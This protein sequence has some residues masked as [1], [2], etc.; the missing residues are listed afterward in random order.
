MVNRLQDLV[1][2][3][4]AA[5]V[6]DFRPRQPIALRDADTHVFFT[7]LHY[8]PNYAYPL[9]VWLH[10]P[11]DNETQL[12]QVLPLVSVRNYVA[13][14][15]RGTLASVQSGEQTGYRWQQSADLILLAE[16][17]VLR[18]I[19]AA[20]RRFNVHDERIVLAGLGCGGTMAVRLALQHPHLVSGAVSL[21]GPF[22]QDHSPLRRWHERRR[23]RLL[24]ASGQTSSEYPPEHVCRDLA[25]FHAANMIVHLR[26]YPCGD[27]LTTEMLADVDR[28][29]MHE[30]IASQASTRATADECQR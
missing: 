15:P 8:E 13:V 21:G 16:N 5:S 17:R 10:G 18:A 12:R 4:V 11:D 3:S 28:W 29:I 25:L 20:R 6:A 19:A 26:H 1:S 27:E 30:F 9:V 24:I 14:G 2:T 7:P 23:L 22:P